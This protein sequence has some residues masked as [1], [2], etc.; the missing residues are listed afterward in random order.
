MADS[1][2]TIVGNLTRDPE[3]RYTANG[4]AYLDNWPNFSQFG[5]RVGTGVGVRY[6]T[7]FGPARL[8]FGIPLNKQQGD[9]PFGIYVS[10]GQAF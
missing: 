3:I 1:S 4:A 10:I 6:Y 5:P 2:I 8:D 9:A 7:D